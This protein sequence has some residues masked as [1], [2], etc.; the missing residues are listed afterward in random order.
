MP[1]GMMTMLGHMVHSD[2]FS[3]QWHMGITGL[4]LGLV[5]WAIAAGFTGWLIILSY[6]K[7]M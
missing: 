3:M 6:N 1:M 4:F 7:L 2:L 5:G